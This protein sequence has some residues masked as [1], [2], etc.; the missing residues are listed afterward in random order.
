MW[1]ATSRHLQTKKPTAVNVK[2]DTRTTPRKKNPRTGHTQYYQP[3]SAS[4]QFSDNSHPISPSPGPETRP[5]PRLLT[6][7]NIPPIYVLITPGNNRR[8]DL[9]PHPDFPAH[10]A[11]IVRDVTGCC[12]RRAISPSSDWPARTWQSTVENVSRRFDVRG[13]GTGWDGTNSD[14]HEPP[15]LGWSVSWDASALRCQGS[16]PRGSRDGTHAQYFNVMH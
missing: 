11:P 15:V 9:P 4:A 6:Q 3:A 7:S 8:I 16:E 5:Y 10:L 14:G 13:G 2:P 12:A 1:V